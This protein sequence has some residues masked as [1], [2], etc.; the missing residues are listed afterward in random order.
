MKPEIHPDQLADYSD[1]ADKIAKY[2]VSLI[3]KEPDD[4]GWRKIFIG[5]NGVFYAYAVA[6][7]FS[8]GSKYGLNHGRVSKLEIYQRNEITRAIYKRHAVYDRG[9]QQRP[10]TDKDRACVLAILEAFPEP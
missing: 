1:R 4:L 7:V 3:I 9:W 6:R 8:V 5:V 2:E 10:R